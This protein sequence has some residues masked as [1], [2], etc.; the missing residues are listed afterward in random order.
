[1]VKNEDF[2]DKTRK[3]TAFNSILYII[4]LSYKGK[5]CMQCDSLTHLHADCTA[6]STI[7]RNNRKI[8]TKLLIN[9]NHPQIKVDE[10][11]GKNYGQ[12]LKL[13]HQQQTTSTQ[14]RHPNR[15][16]PCSGNNYSSPQYTNGN[17]NRNL[18]TQTLY[19]GFPGGNVRPS[20][21]HPKEGSNGKK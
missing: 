11:I 20:T 19:K 5:L 8:F 16:S 15:P 1:M 13:N 4:L 21:F 17:F 3:L 18:S 9:R 14:L 12:L 10:N 6:P 2:E 7:G